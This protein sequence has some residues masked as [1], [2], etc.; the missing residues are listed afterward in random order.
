MQF[1]RVTGYGDV[2]CTDASLTRYIVRFIL[3]AKK[4]RDITSD[5]GCDYN[6]GQGLIASASTSH[7]WFVVRILISVIG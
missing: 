3:I 5:G 1:C 6:T 4:F 2:Y 7:E